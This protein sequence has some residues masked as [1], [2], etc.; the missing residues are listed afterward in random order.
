MTGKPWGRTSGRPVQVELP[1]VGTV[2]RRARALV[3]APVLAQ[4]DGG[5]FFE[6]VTSPL[7][8]AGYSVTVVDTLSLLDSSV[9]SLD[10]LAARWRAELAGPVDLLAG[11]ALG[12]AIAQ[13]LAT[14]LDP[15]DGVLLVSAPTR[16]DAVLTSRLAEIAELAERCQLSAALQLLDARVRPEGVPSPPES[17]T[18]ESRTAESAAAAVPNIASR[19]QASFRL[20]RGLPL[21]FGLDLVAQVRAYPGKL[22]HVV[23]ARSQLV[24]T[25]HVAGAD[26]HTTVSVAGAG[27]RP[28]RDSP[29]TMSAILH[30]FI[31]VGSERAC[32]ASGVRRRS[33]QHGAR[34]HS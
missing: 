30:E 23:G 13:L 10:E 29:V 25:A 26:H 33:D 5:G 8:R 34:S 4:W 15:A 22:T 17:A 7:R 14:E 16:A 19:A 12:G 11:N 32:P 27:M 9:S 6:T 2:G 18:A 28:Q 20:A 3:M 21:L 31:G 1:P 24:T